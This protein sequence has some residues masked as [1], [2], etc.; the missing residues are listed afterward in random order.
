MIHAEQVKLLKELMAHLDSGTNVDAG[1][2]R[3]NPTSAY[4]DPSRAEQE[5]HQ[6][7]RGHPQVI[8]LTGDIPD[9]GSFMTMDDLGMPILATRDDQG[10]FHAFIN[11]CRHR[12]TA[13]ESRERGTARRFTCPFHAWVFSPDGALVGLPRA[14]HFGEIDTS[15]HGLIEL[16]SEER[17]GLLWVHPDPGESLDAAALLGPELDAE[18]E[19]W[20]FGRNRLLTTD[21]YD[22]K[23]NWKLAMDTFGETYHFPSLHRD[24]LAQSFH[25]NVQC[26]DDF[27]RNHRMILCRR[28]I[29][30]M[31]ALPEAEWRITVG[32]LPV[33]FVF[34]NVILLPS[35]SGMQLVRAYPVPGEPNRHRSRVN[36]Y[37]GPGL[38]GD[39]YA[40]AMATRFAEVIRDED[41]VAAASSQVAADSGH[42]PHL[43]FGRNE[44]A[45]HHYHNVFNEAL[46]LDPLP[47]LEQ[48]TT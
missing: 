32:G 33:Y 3:E 8:G 31:R 9:P 10:R 30:T 11:A 21:T 17:H 39:E 18:I 40:E 19:S 1:G 27:G 22:A 38:E 47:L 45:L 13:V 5:W 41:Y 16:P 26:Y 23:L 43:L 25:G 7:F 37:L 2:F 46:G 12:G 24:T 42:V 4:T 15:C 34:P 35:Q 44:P 20:D 14:D 28:D 29:D 6:L 48:P 36:F